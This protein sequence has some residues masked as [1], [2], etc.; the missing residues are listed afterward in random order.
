MTSGS[1]IAATPLGFD[2]SR[3]Y[4]REL[5]RLNDAAVFELDSAKRREL[6]IAQGNVVNDNAHLGLLY[7][8]KAIFATQPRLRNF[9]VN[10]FS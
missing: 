2:Y 5:D 6:L 4:N 8:S 1:C 9:H 10:A 3:I 7:F